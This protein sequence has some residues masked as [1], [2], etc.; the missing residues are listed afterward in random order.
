MTEPTYPIKSGPRVI[1]LDVSLTATGIASSLGWCKTV[2]RSDV[3]TAPLLVRVG[4]VGDLAE[5][6]LRHVGRPEL[7]VIETPAFRALGGGVLER[8][9]LWWLVVRGLIARDVPVAEVNPRT[10]M[11]YATG[12][13]QASKLAV[14]DAVARR[15]PLFLTYG[16]D[17]LADAAVLAAMGADRLGAPIASVPKTHR[18]ALDAVTWPLGLIDV[19]GE[20]V[21]ATK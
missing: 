21:E 12:K 7:V 13:G 11:R 8:S 6:I 19:R 4:Q 15:Y 3:T 18:V 16:N 10:R 17:N 2:G 5:S 14:V 1:G 9:A 20:P